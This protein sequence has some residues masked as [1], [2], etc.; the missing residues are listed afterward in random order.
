MCKKTLESKSRH[1]FQPCGCKNNAFT[2]GGHD[3]QRIGCVDFTKIE[4]WD[5]EKE[6][7]KKFKPNSKV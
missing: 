3:Y 7:F 1:D 2:D 6:K 4:I 5:C